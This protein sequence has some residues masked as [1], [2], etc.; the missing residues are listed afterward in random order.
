MPQLLI[1]GVVVIVAKKNVVV[2]LVLMV[3]VKEEIM[4]ETIFVVE[5]VDEVI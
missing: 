4:G 3:V 1:K 5:A 2:M